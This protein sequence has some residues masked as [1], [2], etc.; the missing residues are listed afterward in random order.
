MRCEACGCFFRR[1]TAEEIEAE[2]VAHDSGEEFGIDSGAEGAGIFAV[3][4]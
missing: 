1:G 2:V 4:G 3:E